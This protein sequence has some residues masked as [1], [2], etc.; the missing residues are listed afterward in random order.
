ME[1]M[2]SVC[3]LLAVHVRAMLERCALDYEKLQEIRLRICQPVFL[4]YDGAECVLCHP[5]W[6]S[7]NPGDGWRITAEEMKETLE[8]VSGYSLYAFDE[9]I[10]RGFLTVPG[11][12]RV[13]L[14]GHTVM[15]QDRVRVMRYISFLN[16]RIS[17]QRKGCADPVLP[18]LYENGEVCHTLILS[19]PGGGKTT[20]LRDL[21]RRISEGGSYGKGRTVGVVDERSEI[22]GSY[23]GVPQN[24]LGPRTDVMD[25]CGKAEGMRMLLRSMAPQVIAVDEL[26]S[27]SDGCAVESVFHCGCRLLATVHGASMDEICRKPLLSKMVRKKMFER[28]IVL[29]DAQRTGKVRE[30]LDRD[31][32]MLCNCCIK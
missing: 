15:D 25:A 6:L 24:D 12:H 11:G 29:S 27:D 26:G 32:K 3:Q 14:A 17:H 4:F 18:F 8:Y 5:G 22:A 30:I 16:I 13:G 23:L 2:E 28:Y 21:I 31:Q 20:L 10:C 9:E 19:P 1:R 7:D